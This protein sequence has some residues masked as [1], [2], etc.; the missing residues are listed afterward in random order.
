MENE[1]YSKIQQVRQGRDWLR[2]DSHKPENWI[3][4]TL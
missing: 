3:C 1:K 2:R 4:R